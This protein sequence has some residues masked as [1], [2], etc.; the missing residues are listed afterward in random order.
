[1]ITI[2]DFMETVDYAITEGSEF[3]WKC[4][5]DSARYLDSECDQF[6]ISIV[7]DTKTSQVY[8]MTAADYD[9]RRSYRWIHPDY[10][11]AHQQECREKGVDAAAM[12]DDEDYIDLEVEQDMLRKAAAIFAGED[13]D[14]RLL[15]P[16]E[17]PDDKML[18]LMKQAHEQDITFNQHMENVLRA[19]CDEM[20]TRQA[21]T[22]S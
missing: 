19:A 20:L 16:L 6:S 7:F 1:M 10:K 2:K 5:G 4:Y 8:E 12:C 9:N 15:V 18:E 17:L 22:S 3:Q 13:Y 21:Q 14:S 11:D